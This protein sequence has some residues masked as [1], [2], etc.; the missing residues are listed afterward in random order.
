MCAAVIKDR[1]TSRTN[2]VASV[3]STD[4]TVSSWVSQLLQYLCHLLIVKPFSQTPA[5]VQIEVIWVQQVMLIYE[6]RLEKENIFERNVC[7]R[8]HS[9]SLEQFPTLQKNEPLLRE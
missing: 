2:T 8:V 5:D 3:S 1:C 7:A 4:H 6:I 9:S